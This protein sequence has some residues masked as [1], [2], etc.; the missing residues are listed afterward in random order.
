[1]TKTLI[2]EALR[3]IAANKLRFLSVAIIIAMGMSFYV[4]INSASP[5]MNYE[6]NEYFDRNN[7]MDVYVSS[8]IPFTNE[9]IEKIKNIKNVTQVM[10]SRYIDGYATLGRETLV[11]KNGT[12]LVLR[13]SS[14]D[15]E[16]E[17]QFLQGEDDPTFLNRLD[18]KEGR[19]PEKVGECVVDE[20]SAELYDDIE[21]GKTLNITDADSTA[22][23]SLENN[24]FVIVGT[25]T[26]PIYISLDRG[27]T[28]LGSGSLDS[29]IYVLPEAFSSSEVNALAVK[30]KYSDA[31]DTF[32]DKYSDRANLIA[33]QIGEISK[34]A[35]DSKLVE[36]K[37]EYTQ[38]I[39]D[40]ESE[41]KAFSETSSKQLEEK[42]ASIKEFKEYVDSED[43]ILKNLKSSNESKT[44]SAA[45]TL[46]SLE[47]RL[48]TVQKSYDAHVKSRDSQSSEIKGYSELKKLYDDLNKK[49]TAAKTELDSL[50][51]DYQSKKSELD[52]KNAEIARHESNISSYETKIS[53]LTSEIEELDKTISSI[54]SNMS[55]YS[56]RVDYQNS[57]VDGIKADIKK[58][59]DIISDSSATNEEKLS[60]LSKRTKLNSD[61]STAQKE[62]T[63]RKTELENAQSQLASAK[64]EKAKKETEKKNYSLALSNERTALSTAKSQRDILK[65]EC[66]NA[67]TNYNSAKKNYDA[68]SATLSKYASS[69]NE[70]TKGQSSLTKL[71]AS[72]E[73]EAE[74]LETLKRRVTEAQIS[75]TLAARNSSIEISKAEYDLKVA[76]SRYGTVDDEYTEL[77]NDIDSKT[78][79]LNGELRNYQTTLSNLAN[80]RWNAIPRND[81]TG[82]RSLA[83]SLENIK[84]MSTVFPIVFFL[85]A[86]IAC[87]V[88]MIKNV[89][90]ERKE[91][92][93]LKAFG[94]SNLS[95]AC[96]FLLY[97]LLA[98]IIG[99]FIGTVMGTCVLPFVICSIYNMTYSVPNVGTVFLANYV[100][101]G[102]ALS[103]I[104]VVT[105]TL[106]AVIHE[107]R[108]NPAIL[109]RPKNIAY[110]RRH[111]FEKIPG[112]WG[113]MSYGM[114]VVAR[115]ISRSR[116]RV[117]AGALG[118][119]CCTALILS[120]LGLINSTTAVSGA[121]YAD[122][123]I[124]KY[125]IMFVLRTPQQDDA[126]VLK[127]IQSDQ[128]TQ[129]ATLFC[130]R[131]A[132]ASAD[133]TAQVKRTVS[134][135]TMKNIEEI[136]NYANFK[137]TAGSLDFGKGKAI[138]T[139]QMAQDL[140]IKVGS[141]VYLSSSDGVK[142]SATVSGIVTNYTNHYVYMT[143]E[144]YE[145]VFGSEPQRKYIIVAAKPYVD[146][147]DIKNLA[148]DFLKEDIVTGAS[149]ASEMASSVD[150]SIS[151]ILAVV[152]MFV[153]SACLL[154]LIVMYTNSNVNLSERTREIANIKVI[155]LS[156][157]EVLMYVIRESVI[158]T[159]YGVVIGLIAGIFL[160][161]VLVGFISVDNI[162]YSS[163]IAWWSYFVTIA[164]ISL[165]SFISS[166][167]I[168][169][170]IDRI[171]MA[172]TLKEIE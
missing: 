89:E 60:A 23:V 109:M 28:K 159:V 112:L 50:E 39:K 91:I 87:L 163:S 69:M 172:E 133:E 44:K 104:M 111:I 152:M 80:L 24:K 100:F 42:E 165:I 31:L 171:N 26:S 145:N 116:E 32:S 57:V 140:G 8:S 38:K 34:D 47:S 113:K 144:T 150:V 9:D 134:I 30:M 148:S 77:K 79:T 72:V 62:L 162:V 93:V 98:W 117:T 18:L 161:K 86:M 120:S 20:K 101:F 56:Q 25:V 29:Y 73:S 102:I 167:P 71:I 92:G 88:I 46:S 12:E 17:K 103:F 138:I 27:Q 142:R 67:A 55:Y 6:S 164:I 83:V 16:K 137:L 132:F 81:F 127:K 154:A 131:S 53:K 5:A 36:L 146:E 158:S 21:I 4:G 155:G 94:Y 58:Q 99:I 168:R 37:N 108:H 123:G 41:I 10:S 11:N 75:Y 40:K 97:A 153:L 135:I 68:D 139:N 78:D 119:A 115:T 169:Y 130:N 63:S 7:L 82:M 125:D 66:S 151:R 118:I 59:N 49:H 35:I 121:Q 43:K 170:K 106:I 22:G 14:L 95:I 3:S 166:L 13:I 84:S 48:S 156:D 85:T 129:S 110:N 54:N 52:A 128:R 1:M 45:S 65:T 107:I 64:S 122:D 33:E 19:L 147:Q 90:E 76:K 143:D 51:G 160:H 124:F 70:L 114:I 136:S 149:T 96:K 126:K 61:L 105:A 74:E 15:V 141:K 157:H 2:K